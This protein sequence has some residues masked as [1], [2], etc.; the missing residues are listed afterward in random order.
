MGFV[1][2]YEFDEA[3]IRFNEMLAAVETGEEIAITRHG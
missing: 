1:C 2:T 3:K